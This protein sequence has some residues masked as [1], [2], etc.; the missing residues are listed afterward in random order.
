MATVRSYKLSATDQEQTKDFGVGWDRL[1]IKNDSEVDLN[2]SFQEAIDANSYMIYPGTTELFE[3]S[4]TR[5]RY[6]VVSGTG[7]VH[8]LLMKY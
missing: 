8:I 2:I 1:R 6:K 7:T 4:V 5:L 3:F